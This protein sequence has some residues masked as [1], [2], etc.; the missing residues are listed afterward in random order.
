MVLNL[1]RVEDI[2]PE[3]LL[4]KSFYQFQHCAKVPEMIN[5]LD[6]LENELKT[7]Q[8]DNEEQEIGFLIFCFSTGGEYKG[9]G[10]K[11]PQTRV[12]KELEKN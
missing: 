8:V 9:C 10:C 3:W 6:E 2:N 7:V 5:S 4:E 1:L 12:C 11:E